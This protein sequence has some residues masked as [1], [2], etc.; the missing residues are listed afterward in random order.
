MNINRIIKDRN[1][2]RISVRTISNSNY[3]LA[4]LL[5]DLHF[6]PKSNYLKE[7]DIFYAQ[8][9]LKTILWKDL[10]YSFEQI[11]E[12]DAKKRANFLVS[13]FSDELTL[14]YTNGDWKNYH[15]NK[16][17]TGW[18]PL[19]KSTFD[20]GVLFVNELVCTSIWVEDED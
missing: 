16:S 11:S 6:E 14:F 1:N 3:K 8:E 2:G 20:A 10:A 13:L 12:S 7:C 5:D 9:V 17:N 19:T 15:T 4:G 18:S